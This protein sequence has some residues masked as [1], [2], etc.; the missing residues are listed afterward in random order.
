MLDVIPPVVGVAPVRPTRQHDR[1][2]CEAVTFTGAN[3]ATGDID[4]EQRWLPP[5]HR[6]PWEAQHTANEHAV[7]KTA[8]TATSFAVEGGSSDTEYDVFD[9]VTGMVRWIIS[10]TR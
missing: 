5:R 3:G 9:T 1:Q 10:P 7:E 8:R 6:L 2:L 4:S